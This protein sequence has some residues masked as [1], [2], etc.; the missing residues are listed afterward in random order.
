MTSMFGAG[1]VGRRLPSATDVDGWVVESSRAGSARRQTTSAENALATRAIA[2]V[3]A[4]TSAMTGRNHRTRT[5]S[6]RH[7]PPGPERED[8][9][10]P[11]PSIRR[12]DEGLEQA[13]VDLRARSLRLVE[14]G[15]RAA[16]V[17]KPG[18]AALDEPDHRRGRRPME[19]VGGRAVGHPA[20]QVA[21][22]LEVADDERRPDPRAARRVRVL[23]MPREPRLRLARRR[24][25]ASVAERLAS[26]RGRSVA[27]RRRRS[28]APATRGGRD[29][30]RRR[31]RWS[32]GRRRARPPPQCRASRRRRSAGSH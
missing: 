25:H 5:S 6:G 18:L 11:V 31:R 27:R 9:A 22:R 21:R 19:P 7:R 15:C 2:T 26:N 20:R 23:G 29:T 8:R 13:D 4:A 24:R 30:A 16:Q 12:R 3:P 14:L 17:A 32:R 10:A 28:P 1:T